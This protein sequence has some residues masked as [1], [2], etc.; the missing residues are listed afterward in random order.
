MTRITKKQYV[1]TF[2]I[3]GWFVVVMV[4]TTFIRGANYGGSV[5]LRL[6]SG[7]VNAWNQWSLSEWQLIIFNML[8]FMPLGFLLPLLGEKTRRSMPV[9]ILSL[10]VTLGIEFFQMFTRRGIFEFDDI[11]HNTLGSM[12][13]YFLINAI[14]ES[15]KH[16]KIAVKP[17]LKALCIPL[18]FTILFSGALIV[19]HSKELGNLSIR[20]AYAQDMNQIEVELNLNLPTESESVS[21]YSSKQVQSRVY[22]QD[23]ATIVKHSF[24]LRQLGGIRID[25]T[26]RIWTL[27]DNEGNHY[28]FNYSLHDGAWWLA[29]EGDANGPMDQEK[30]VKSREYYESKMLSSGILPPNAIFSIQNGNT[31]RWDIKQSVKDIVRGDSDFVEGLIMIVPSGK[32]Q[33]PHNLFYFMKENKFVR[34]VDIISPAQAFEDI[35]KGNFTMYHDLRNG[36]RLNIDEYEL[37]YSYDSKGYYQPVYRFVGSLNGQ[38]WETLIPAVLLTD[39]PN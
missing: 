20:P 17:L 1:T 29:T 7:Y 38:P 32:Y 28:T 3:L 22:G 31:L 11:L 6:F 9:I 21:L 33:I 18:A 27:R 15:A 2:L 35:L 10:L 36:D 5:N 24:G 16:R 13:G 19:Y 4:L 37:A 14:L 30:L 25:G 23:M 8:M 26:N 12:A 39:R 34:E